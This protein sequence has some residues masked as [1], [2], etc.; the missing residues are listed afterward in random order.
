ML[1]THELPDIEELLNELER[2]A[3]TRESGAA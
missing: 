2:L 3:P 1:A